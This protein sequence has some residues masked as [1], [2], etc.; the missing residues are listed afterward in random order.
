M[1]L[2]MSRSFAIAAVGLFAL[3]GCQKPA[4]EGG[5]GT[6][7]RYLGVGVY[8]PGPMWG[9][10]ARSGA[11]A[12]AAAATLKDD[13]QVIVVVDSKTGEVRQCGNLS[14]FCIEMN[15]WSSA[16]P[17]TPIAVLKHT[18]VEGPEPSPSSA[19]PRQGGD[20]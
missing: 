19:R 18:P 9:Q 10:I 17:P 12:D 4:P 13:E 2:S 15:P 5:A 1:G 6:H 7:D 16:A 11:P 14:G 3:A 8:A 20:P